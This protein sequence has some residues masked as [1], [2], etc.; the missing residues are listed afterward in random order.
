M[1]TTAF[2]GALAVLALMTSGAAS[3]QSSAPY[4]APISLES[5]KAVGAAVHAEAVKRKVPGTFAV[6]DILGEMVVVDRGMDASNG[7]VDIALAKARSA[8]KY[9]KANLALEG[10]PAGLDGMGAGGALLMSGGKI[11]G[12]IGVSGGAEGALAQAGAAASK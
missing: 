5:A 1:K 2:A 12:A 10:F 7:A 6:V 3:A 9:K 8:I 4:G 11:V